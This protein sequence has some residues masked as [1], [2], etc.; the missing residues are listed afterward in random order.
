M[1]EGTFR[2]GR[3][4]RRLTGEPM[5]IG[6]R[7]LQ[8]IASVSGWIGGGGNEEGSGGGALLSVTPLEVIVH[9]AD[10]R[11]QRVPTPDAAGA[12]LKGI[13]LAGLGG[14][15]IWLVVRLIVRRSK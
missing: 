15:L 3:V 12:A 7:T 2:P 5:T 1:A 9:E 8:P 6:G 14:P 13:L 10:D 4:Q 11:E